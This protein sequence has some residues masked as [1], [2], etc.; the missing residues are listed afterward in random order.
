MGGLCERCKKA[1]ATYHLTDIDS[2][3]DRSERH[4]CERC[5]IDEGLVQVH[6]SSLT[7]DILEQFVSNAKSI[8]ATRSE[9][10]CPDCGL[11]YLE[12][13]NQGQLGCPGD[14]DA[15]KEALHPLI[16]REHDGATHH[17]GKTPRA[18]AAGRE[19]EADI[20]RLRRQLEDAVAAEDYERAAGLRDRL[21]ELEHS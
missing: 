4:L 15:F 19:A 17:I 5:A 12:F 13:R 2:D 11:S 10:V 20:R 8:A 7:A 9:M 21:R 14:Y 1:Q 16:E 18:F 3:G 6:K